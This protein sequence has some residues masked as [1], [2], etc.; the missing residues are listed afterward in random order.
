VADVNDAEAIP[1]GID[2]E[3]PNAPDDLFVPPPWEYG[4]EPTMRE[5]ASS[6]TELHEKFDAVLAI[7]SGIKDQ[8]QPLVDSLQELPFLGKALRKGG[9]KP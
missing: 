7:I 3:S 6:L 1:A 9:N 8:V 4:P 2:E 5:L